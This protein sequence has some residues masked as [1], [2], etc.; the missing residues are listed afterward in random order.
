MSIKSP[1][2][3]PVPD[4]V[5]HNAR[6]RQ[7]KLMDALPFKFKS[8]IIEYGTGD[9]GLFFLMLQGFPPDKITGL[10]QA[11]THIHDVDFRTG[12]GPYLDHLRTQE[13]ME[14]RDGD[15]EMPPVAPSGGGVDAS[16]GLER[17]LRPRGWRRRGRR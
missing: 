14:L 2:P 11:L 1:A 5:A 13:L 9:E 4:W 16:K 12:P 6:V 15:P 8:V 10:F 7:M 3:H 17:Y